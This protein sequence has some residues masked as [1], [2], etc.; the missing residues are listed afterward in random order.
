M[1]KPIKIKN[2]TQFVNIIEHSEN[3]REFFIAINGG[4]RSWKLITHSMK[5]DRFG[6]NKL[7]IANEIDNTTQVLSISSVMNPKYSNI[8]SAIRCGAFYLYDNN[9]NHDKSDVIYY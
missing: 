5:K 1:E 7:L 3:V 2:I 9:E 6:R 8:P 4:G